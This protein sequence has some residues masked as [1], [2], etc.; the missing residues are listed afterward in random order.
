MFQTLAGAR[1]MPRIGKLPV[2]PAIAPGRVLPGQTDHHLDGPGGD[3]RAT[4]GLRVGPLATDQLTMP[5][6]QG[7]GLDEEPMK[8]RPGDQP[9]EAGKE[10]SIRGSQSGAG[11][12]PTEDGHLVAEHDDLDGQ[13]A[14]VTPAQAEQLEDP[15]EGEIEKRQSHGSVSWFSP[16]CESPDQ[17]TRMTFLAHREAVS[18]GQ[19][20][21]NDQNTV[22]R[23]VMAKKV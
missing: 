6:E 19:L 22:V 7:V 11:H 17:G 15:D 8:L 1:S 23:Q 4:G 16:I 14:A 13:I 18:G 12:L 20:V 10:R 2:D 9:A 21:F 3:P 5:T